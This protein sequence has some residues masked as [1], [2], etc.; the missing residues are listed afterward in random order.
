MNRK[1]LWL[2][3]SYAWSEIG[4]EDDEFSNHA[5]MIKALPKDMENFRKEYY[6]IILPALSTET[7]CALVSMGMSLPDWG[8]RDGYVIG[9]I[10]KWHNRPVIK[11]I[12]NPI[13]MIGYPLSLLMSLSYYNKTKKAVIAWQQSA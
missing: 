4:L 10:S 3:I 11:K 12:L 2:T 7:I 1:R 13:W 8:F 5:E 9:K 6:F